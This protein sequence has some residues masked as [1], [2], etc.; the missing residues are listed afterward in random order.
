MRGSKGWY[1]REGAAG[2]D[3][4]WACLVERVGDDA[5]LLLGLQLPLHGVRLARAGLAGARGVP[6]Q[7]AESQ[8][9]EREK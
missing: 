3:P 9:A 4:L 5:L 8:R 1:G 2:N 6:E 7:G